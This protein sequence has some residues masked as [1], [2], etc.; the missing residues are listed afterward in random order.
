MTSTLHCAQQPGRHPAR[1]IPGPRGRAN[2][3][4][5]IHLFN[6]LAPTLDEL[7]A[8]DGPICQLGIPGVRVVV[9][10]DPALT[11]EIFSMKADTFRW[12]HKFNVIG[13]PQAAFHST[14]THVA[15][16]FAVGAALMRDNR[17]E[18]ETPFQI[19]GG[20]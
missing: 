14:S 19:L 11:H 8:T 20:D 5:F 12:S 7:H 18:T 15:A 13:V 3:R 10:G 2:L 1:S 17:M 9:I 6:Q 16:S 4:G